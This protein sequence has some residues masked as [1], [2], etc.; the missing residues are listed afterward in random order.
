MIG[1]DGERERERERE[2]EKESGKS[3]LSEQLDENDDDIYV[4]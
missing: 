4:K 3:I 1:K 2:R